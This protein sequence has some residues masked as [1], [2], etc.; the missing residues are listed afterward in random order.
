MAPLRPPLVTSR[1]SPA[2]PHTTRGSYKISANPQYPPRAG[3]VITTSLTL[4]PSH[5]SLVPT[6][7]SSSTNDD[8]QSTSILAEAVATTHLSWW[9][10]LALILGSV[11]ALVVG[12]WLWWRHRRKKK[13]SKDKKMN[14]MKEKEKK[15]EEDEKQKELLDRIAGVPSAGRKGGRGRGGGNGWKRG[16][17]DESDLE[18]ESEWGESD[19]SISDGGTIRPSRTR[20]RRGRRRGRRRDRDRDRFGHSRR[21]GRRGGEYD[22]DSGTDYSDET[23]LPRRRERDR[24]RDRYDRDRGGERHRGRSRLEISRSPS[25][26]PPRGRPTRQLTASS[27]HPSPPVV[28]TKRRKR[29]TF[30]DSVFSTYTSMKNAA[31]RLKYVEAKVKLQKQLEEEEVLERKRREKVTEANKELDDLRAYEKET[32]RKQASSDNGRLL[33]PPVKR[34]S[35]GFPSQSSNSY[36]PSI[37][38]MPPARKSAHNSRARD[39]AA[40]HQNPPRNDGNRRQLYPPVHA[41]SATA[42]P[43]RP[44]KK[45]TDDSLSVELS[46]L[47]EDGSRSGARPAPPAPLREPSQPKHSDSRPLRSNLKKTSGASDNAQFP[48]AQNQQTAVMIPSQPKAAWN[49]FQADWLSHPIVDPQPTKP[50]QTDTTAARTDSVYLPITHPRERPTIPEGKLARPPAGRFQSGAAGSG[51]ITTGSGRNGLRT[52]RVGAG[53]I[54]GVNAGGAA[55][56]SKWADRLRDRRK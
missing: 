46:Y 24:R 29:D 26:Q 5:T 3:V 30:R 11:L 18:S 31:V 45:A 49:P 32:E 38:V 6:I 28:A 7:P 48:S 23:Y 43:S 42:R 8:S 10:L 21:G 36:R 37:P 34:S 25:P 47:L 54:T 50:V 2:G 1:I 22:S 35:T 13:K 27:T 12:I 53:S 51:P 15:R 17:S 40:G 56:A 39:H 16:D 4:T 44:E 52:N 20:R 55:G 14:E 33:I 41:T 9:Q 19:D